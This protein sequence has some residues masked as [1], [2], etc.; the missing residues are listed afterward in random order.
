MGQFHGNPCWYELATSGDNLGAAGDF[1]AKVMGWTITDSGMPDF[2]YHLACGDGPGDMV[3]GLME[4]PGDVAGMPPCWM[5]YFSVDDVDQF[6]KDAVAAGASVHREPAD[7]PG[8]GRFA[9]LADPQ[10][11]AFGILQPDTSDMSPEDIAR[12]EAGELGAFNQKKVAH[13]NWN[14]LMTTAPEAALTFYGKLLGWQKSTSVPMGEMGTYQLFSHKGADIGGM[15]GLGN[16][17]VPAWLPYFGANGVTAAMARITESGGTII[18]GP[19]EVP[20]GAFIAIAQDP[21]GAHFAVV[22]PREETR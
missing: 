21:Q 2:T 5:I 3:A 14:E 11:A 18:H 7:I 10:G 15:M 12:A 20:G 6:C 22:G 16:S 8:T 19:Q 4:M 17:P 1:Y 13:G 9:I